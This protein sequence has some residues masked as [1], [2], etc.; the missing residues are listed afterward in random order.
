M[1][2]GISLS[3]TSPFG[4]L[5]A[6]TK[7]YNS[8]HLLMME[9]IYIHT[10]IYVYIYIYDFLPIPGASNRKRKGEMVAQEKEECTGT[11]CEPELLLPRCALRLLVVGLSLFLLAA[12]RRGAGA[13]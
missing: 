13:L 11:T 2:T 7:W 8:F 6:H 1:L 12:H 3:S 4:Y 10:Y 9:Y 5:T